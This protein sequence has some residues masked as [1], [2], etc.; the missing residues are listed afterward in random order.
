MGAST[1]QGSGS[2]LGQ[3]PR[4]DPPARGPH[5][6]HGG[7]A[8]SSLGSAGPGASDRATGSSHRAMLLFVHTPLNGRPARADAVFP[9]VSPAPEPGRGYRRCPI[10]ARSPTPTYPPSRSFWGR[11]RLEGVARKKRGMWE[12]GGRNH[13]AIC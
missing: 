3:V 13:S 8:S 6:A 4:T 5:K 12:A 11:R 2:M 7:R 10:N 1:E 9:S